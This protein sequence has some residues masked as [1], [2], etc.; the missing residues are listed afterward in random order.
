MRVVLQRL[1]GNVQIALERLEH[2]LAALAV[3]PLHLDELL[4]PRLGLALGQLAVVG[5]VV[6]L[7]RRQVL[8][9]LGVG[10]EPRRLLEEVEHFLLGVLAA[11]L[12][13]PRLVQ[14]VVPPR[15]LCAGVGRPPDAL[16]RVAAQQRAGIAA[17]ARLHGVDDL[18]GDL[19]E[20]VDHRPGQFQRQHVGH[21]GWAFQ[22]AEQH[23]AVHIV[24]AEYEGLLRGLPLA[25][26]ARREPLEE[27]LEGG[28]EQLP[29]GGAHD[30]EPR[31][32]DT[33]SWVGAL[34]LGMVEDLEQA[35]CGLR[36]THR[37][38]Y[39]AVLLEALDERLP[40]GGR[41]VA[42]GAHGYT[43]IVGV[44]RHIPCGRFG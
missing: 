13:G 3:A 42:D 36:T 17:G 2:R 32:A 34:A 9:V 14:P 27:R 7:V 40:I 6:R 38:G 5:V 21:V 8:Q 19:D 1:G 43:S 44:P 18:T 4:D 11:F 16:P 28:V 31:I 12:L 10:A 30:D 23:L 15:V 39:E 20:L 35:R 33:V 25:G 22:R 41:G 24:E 37:S 26:D 29:V